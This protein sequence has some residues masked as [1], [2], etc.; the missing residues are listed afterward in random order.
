[1]SADVTVVG[2]DTTEPTTDTDADRFE[3]IRQELQR[4]VDGGRRRRFLVRNA[5]RLLVVVAFVSIWSFS[6][7]RWVDEFWI[8]PPGEVWDRLWEWTFDGT[9]QHHLTYTLQAMLVGLVVGTLVGILVG[10]VLGSSR[11]LS[12][13]FEPFVLIVYS[14]PKIALAPLFI[15]WFGIG[16]SSKIIMS[17]VIVFFLVFYNTYSGVRSVEPEMVDAVK[18]LGANRRDVVLHVVLPSSASWIY[19]GVTMAVPYALIGAI[20][21]ELIASNRG[22]GHLLRSSSGAFDSTGTI[23]ALLVLITVG[24]VIN[25]LVRWHQ[26]RTSRW[27]GTKERAGGAL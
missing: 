27:M 9:I 12:E 1:M 24:A 8:S 11:L 19:T 14:I 23:A 2:P 20:V 6:V 16:L 4:T 22:L 15:L 7:N 18:I 3:R 13:I 25:G 26:S 5:G 17:G 10:F 21:G